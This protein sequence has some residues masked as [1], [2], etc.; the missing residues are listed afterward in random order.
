MNSNVN[1]RSEIPAEVGLNESAAVAAAASRDSLLERMSQ[2][3]GP[4]KMT[5]AGAAIFAGM[6]ARGTQLA[7]AHA[8]QGGWYCCNLARPDQWCAPTGDSNVFWCDH[9]GFKRV[10]YCCLPGGLVG[11]GE[12]Q[13][14]T[15]DCH[16][17][18]QY[19]CSYGWGPGAPC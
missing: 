13:S 8:G 4:R 19:Y 12:C 2:W 10:W 1:L 18:S 5:L 17:G 9:G 7:S 6:A 3:S 16:N 11:C 14:S 15:A